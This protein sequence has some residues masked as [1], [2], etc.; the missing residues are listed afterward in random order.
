MPDNDASDISTDIANSA[1]K[2]ASAT[3]DGNSVSQVPI[4]D[5]IKALEHLEG[6]QAS[7]SNRPGLGFRFQQI[8]PVYE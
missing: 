4:A 3:V 5:K 2:P 8:R 6:R 7:A 1:T